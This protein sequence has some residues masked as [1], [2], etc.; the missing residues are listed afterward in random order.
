MQTGSWLIAFALWGVAVLVICA[1][2]FDTAASAVSIWWSRPTYGHSFLVLPIAGFVT[3]IERDRWSQ[4]KPSPGIAGV[5]VSLAAGVLWA[6]AEGEGILE[7]QHLA[8]PVMFIAVAVALIG[9]R[10]AGAMWLPL[11]Y[12]LLLAPFGTPILPFL[13]DVSVFLSTTFLDLAGITYYGEGHHIQVRTGNYIVAPGCAGLN[14]ILAT[15][16]IGPLFCV[17]IF[18]SWLKRLIVLAAMMLIVIVANGVRIFGIIALAELTNKQID[19][20]ADHLFYGWAF[21]SVVLV[22][23]MGVA[24]FFADPTERHQTSALSLKSL[25]L[26]RSQGMPMQMGLAFFAAVAASLSGLILHAAGL[27]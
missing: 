19:I 3:W 25:A 21:F 6:F 7:V 26:A 8:L 14:F 11:A 16:A 10:T 13:Q 5:L 20:S 4:L 15:A 24:S 2:Y 22:A 27:L 23:V 18:Q 12:L 9:V 1:A 17:L